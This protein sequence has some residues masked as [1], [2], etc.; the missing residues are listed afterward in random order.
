MTDL[1]FILCV[2][3]FKADDPRRCFHLQCRKT[4]SVLLPLP[5][6]INE[7]LSVLPFN[8]RLRLFSWHRGYLAMLSGDAK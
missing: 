4:S 3:F 1:C 8:Q 7:I 5:P 6:P 2:M